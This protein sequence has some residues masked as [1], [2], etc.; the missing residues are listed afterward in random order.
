MDCLET[1]IHYEIGCFDN[2]TGKQEIFFLFSN[3]QSDLIG[4]G[5]EETGIDFIEFAESI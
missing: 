1:E 5:D 4:S 3:L 2:A